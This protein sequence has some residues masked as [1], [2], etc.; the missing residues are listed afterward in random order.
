MSQDIHGLSTETIV[1]I[2][3]VGV[4]ILVIALMLALPSRRRWLYNLRRTPYSMSPIHE[5]RLDCGRLTN[6]VDPEIALKSLTRLKAVVA[7][8]DQLV[9]TCPSPLLLASMFK[10]DLDDMVSTVNR[11][12]WARSVKDQ[13]KAFLQQVVTTPATILSSAGRSLLSAVWSATPSWTTIPLTT[14]QFVP[15]RLR[16]SRKMQSSNSLCIAILILFSTFIPNVAAQSGTAAITSNWNQRAMGALTEAVVSCAFLFLPVIIL[17]IG[18]VMTAVLLHKKA[19]G[20]LGGSMSF[21]AIMFVYVSKEGATAP[22]ESIRTAVGTSYMLFMFGYCRRIILRNKKNKGT[23]AI[24][25]LLGL[26]IGSAFL[27]IASVRDSVENSLEIAP[28]C[29]VPL[30]I[31]LGFL[32]CDLY[33]HITIPQQ[34]DRKILRSASELEAQRRDEPEIFSLAGLRRRADY[35]NDAEEYNLGCYGE[36]DA[37]QPAPRASTPASRNWSILPLTQIKAS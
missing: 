11:L 34:D 12:L 26:V 19:E 22:K 21:M 16:Q 4:V 3:S 13:A 23:S 15:M 25:I 1:A 14:A 10:P 37:S 35:D 6:V 8:P 5:L 20:L 9:N 32:L 28:P 29:L 36:G 27:A 2:V 7:K 30:A 33:L 17:M 18:G 31:P 24:A